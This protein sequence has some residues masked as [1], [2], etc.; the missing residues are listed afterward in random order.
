MKLLSLVYEW[1]IGMS[2]HLDLNAIL[3]LAQNSNQIILS[4]V[5]IYNDCIS[6]WYECFGY[7]WEIWGPFKSQVN[8]NILVNPFDMT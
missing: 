8:H 4:F 7:Y 3:I 6:D 5:N 2:T 1:I